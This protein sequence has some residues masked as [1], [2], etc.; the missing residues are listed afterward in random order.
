MRFP[1]SRSNVTS[2]SSPMSAR[3]RMSSSCA[4]G[5]DS[6]THSTSKPTSRRCR[7]MSRFRFSSAS[8]FKSG[9]ALL[10]HSLLF[11]HHLLGEGERG[12]DVLGRDVVVGRQHVLQGTTVGKVFE[13]QLDR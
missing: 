6:L 10:S 4:P 11:R 12:P 13:D 2:T 5:Q 3:E 9:G 8:S 1:K 7:T